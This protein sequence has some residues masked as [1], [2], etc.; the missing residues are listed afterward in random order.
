[1]KLA[2]IGYGKMGIA[3]EQIAVERGHEIVAKVN[4]VNPIESVDFSEVDLAI[5]F[6]R[7]ELAVSHILFCLERNIPIVV[8]TTAWQQHIDVVTEEVKTKKGSLL[9]A[10]NFSIGVNIFFEINKLLA[11]LMEN[12]RTYL[13]TIEE[14]HHTEKLDAP[15][16]TAVSLAKDL[17]LENRNY[18]SWILSETNTS[19]Q[20][21][22]QFSV[23]AHREPDVPGTHIISYDSPIDQIQIKHQ[24]H[25]RQGFALGAVLASEWLLGKKG[26]FTM[27]DV[28][29]LR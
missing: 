26:I 28:L 2:L 3:I 20:N 11:R 5:E 10:S 19:I 9:H 8:G 4:S 13:P 29:K 21:N 6:S 18:E 24:A 23:I 25:N 15:S 1:M 22:G 16:G 17:L 14:I 27:S 7:P 12:H